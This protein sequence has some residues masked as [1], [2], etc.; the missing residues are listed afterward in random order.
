[1]R[2][3]KHPILGLLIL[4]LV[5]T[6]GYMYYQHNKLF[7]ATDDAYVNTKIVNVAAKTSGYLV[8]LY[9]TNNQKVHKGQLLFKLNPNDYQ[10]NLDQ[11]K[12]N[13]LSY[14]SQVNMMQK[15]IVVSKDSLDKDMLQLQLA[16]NTLNR[17]SKM[18]KNQ[19]LSKQNYE[20]AKTNVKSLK[21]QLAIDNN[22]MI[23]Y[24]E[25]MNAVIAKRDQAQIAKQSAQSNVDNTAY[26]SPIDGYVTNLNSLN[27]GEYITASQQLFSLVS[28]NGWW[29]D[30]N[31]KETQLKRIRPGQKVKITLDM[32]DHTYSGIVDSVSYAS[33]NSFSL[34]PAQNA[35]GN[36]VKVTQRFPVIIRVID[37]KNYPLRMGASCNIEIN[38][39]LTP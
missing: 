26:Y 17:Y 10:F 35:T 15:Q 32:Y 13:Y 20:I 21:T 34:L 18:L 27:V 2:K 22:K 33:G 23:Q 1:L 7:P 28:N 16:N 29:I 36:W 24:Q 9:V 14:V 30:A 37:D 11:A 3:Y 6:L 12:Q 25:A 8:E 31:F 39:T 38:T 5:I 19:T 4:V